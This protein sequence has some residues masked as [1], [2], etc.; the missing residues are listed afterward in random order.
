MRGTEGAAAEIIAAAVSPDLDERFA[1]RFP[2]LSRQ[3]LARVLAMPRESPVRRRALERTFRT[4]GGTSRPA[5]G[6]FRTP[7]ERFEGLPDFAFEPTYRTVG[8]LRLAH[9]D[10]GEGAPVVL[11]HGEPA[12][13]LIWRKVIPPIRDAGYRC[14]APDHAGFGRSDKPIDP[15]WQSFE[16]HV[17]LTASLL[18]ELDLRDVSLVLH[19]F[20]GPIGLMLALAKP[21]R[22]ARIVILD[23]AID[24]REAWMNETW[25]RTREFVESTEDFPVGELMRATCLDD[26]GEAVIAAYQ[27][28]F[29][30]P[31]SQGWRGLMLSVPYKGDKSA[32][33]SADAFYDALR[34]DPRPML[35][36]WAESDTF[37]TLA[38]G[39]RLATQIG[40]R[41]DHV[42]P[43]SGHA[44]PEDQAQLISQ[45]IVDWLD[46]CD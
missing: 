37:L 15:S 39:Q 5:G 21:D 44:L 11:L 33:A 7:E 4:H 12:W 30:V 41:I 19:D 46:R 18:E 26:P 2:R 1:L 36:L 13:S 9:I 20:G 6:V 43:Q 25:V 45:L 8:D 31:E 35:F 27:A 32:A 14:V 34:R 17:E 16:R 40:R 42:I 3:L 38:S 29:P 22:I 10:V 28:P 23:T 24:P